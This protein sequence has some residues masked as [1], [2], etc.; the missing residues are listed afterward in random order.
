MFIDVRSHVTILPHSS[1]YYWK[2]DNSQ[3]VLV[4]MSTLVLRL[5]SSFGVQTRQDASGFKI[6][7]IAET[8]GRTADLA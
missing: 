7:G 1:E 5:P 2:R 8:E 6:R 4:E 3:V